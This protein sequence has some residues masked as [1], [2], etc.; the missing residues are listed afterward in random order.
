MWIAKA[1]KIRVSI[2]L[3]SYIKFSSHNTIQAKYNKYKKET[4]KPNI[5]VSL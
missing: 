3:S 2:V 5:K 1:V 4:K